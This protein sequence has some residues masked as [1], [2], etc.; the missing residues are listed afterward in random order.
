MAM[1]QILVNHAEARLARKRGGDQA[2][3][4]LD[5][6]DSDPQGEATDVLKLHDALRTLKAQDPRKA[7]GVELRFFG[8]LSIEET[9]EVLQ[10]ST[11]TVTRDWQVA[12]AWLGREMGAVPQPV[13]AA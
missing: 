4:S 12:R 1:R 10:V 9:A 3:V 2:R 8:G 7:R 6:A 13:I 11:V 5:Q